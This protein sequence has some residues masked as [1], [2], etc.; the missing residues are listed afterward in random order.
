MDSLD[1]RKVFRTSQAINDRIDDVPVEFLLM[2]KQACIE[3]IGTLSMYERL[4]KTP[5]VG[6]DRHVE[7]N[8]NTW[9]EQYPVCFL[10][11]RPYA[12]AIRF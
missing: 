9:Y 4:G 11:F 7:L 6:I 12:D 10:R 1:E 2:G 5:T 3:S 8:D